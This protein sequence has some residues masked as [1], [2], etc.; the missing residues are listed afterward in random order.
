MSGIQPASPSCN[1]TAGPPLPP[2]RRKI[3]SDCRTPTP[4]KLA[5]G[6]PPPGAILPSWRPSPVDARPNKPAGQRGRCTPAK[7][8][9]ILAVRCRS[10]SL[11]LEASSED[12]PSVCALR[13]RKPRPYNWPCRSSESSW[14]LAPGS[15]RNGAQLCHLAISAAPGEADPG[16][17]PAAAACLRFHMLTTQPSRPQV[18]SLTER[19]SHLHTGD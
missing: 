9:P 1:G 3:P 10:P 7:A 16:G 15:G 6:P 2:G 4:L 8:P 14:A 12:R 11:R 5:P 17:R 13:T 19:G 18:A